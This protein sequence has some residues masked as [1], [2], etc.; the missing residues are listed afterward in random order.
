VIVIA[1]LSAPAAALI[2]AGTAAAINV[3]SFLLVGLRQE[4]QRRRELYADALEATLAYREFAYAVPRRRHD[5]RAEERVRISE[6]MREVQRGLARA[7]SLMRIERATEVA[8]K[9]AELVRETRRVAGGYI[10][11]AW[12]DEPIE[13][14]SHMNV[15]GGLDF[16]QIDTYERAYLSQVA[17]DLAWYRFW[18]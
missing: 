18:R 16:S 1:G 15:P 17:A 14:D 13:E 11:K 10:R 3:L 12:D 5:A 6:A 9:Y 2:G 4:R 8:D 7:E